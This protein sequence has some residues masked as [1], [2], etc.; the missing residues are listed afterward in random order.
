ME[1]PDQNKVIG[2]EIAVSK[3]FY[4]DEKSGYALKEVLTIDPIV[5]DLNAV[6]NEA[7][8]DCLKQL[9][10]MGTY[11][12]VAQKQGYHGEGH[13]MTGLV[14]TSSLDPRVCMSVEF[15][16]RWN[17]DSDSQAEKTGEK[18]VTLKW[19]LNDEP[20]DQFGVKGVMPEHPASEEELD[21][22][23]KL[24]EMTSGQKTESRQ[25]V[26]AA[27]KKGFRMLGEADEEGRKPI[28]R[29]VTI[30]LSLKEA[31]QALGHKDWLRVSDYLDADEHEDV[32]HPGYSVNDVQNILAPKGMDNVEKIFPTEVAGAL[33]DAE[34]EAYAGAIKKER[35][36]AIEQ[37]FEKIQPT[38]EYQSGD[39]EW[40]SVRGCGIVSCTLN[41][42]KD[43]V[44]LKIKNPEHLIND[45]VNGVGLFA[46]ELDPYQAASDAEIKSGII[47]TADDYFDVYGDKPKEAELRY[48]PE[49][50]DDF[51]AERL[52]YY[53]SEMSSDQIADA[54]IDAVDSGR[55]EDEQE[56]IDLASKL[57][58]KS[59]AEI[60]KAVK[61][62]HLTSAEK[63]QKR[64]GSVREESVKRSGRKINESKHLKGAAMRKIEEGVFN[65]W[66]AVDFFGLP[67]MES[68]EFKPASA[69][70]VASVEKKDK[71]LDKKVSELG[72]DGEP[73]KAGE[74][75]AK[76]A[77]EVKLGVKSGESEHKESDIKVGDAEDG[78]GE[79]VKG[80]GKSDS[81]Q[82]ALP[83]AQVKTGDAEEGRGK[84]M[85]D[86]RRMAGKSMSEEM[87]ARLVEW[88][89]KKMAERMGQKKIGK[90]VPARK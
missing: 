43:E 23:S 32:Y 51:F 37:A 53:I 41:A 54:V 29:E 89:K 60:A 26:L 52:E 71:E 82:K 56:A 86:S 90:K 69:P 6:S 48:V 40:I 59:K 28:E 63:Y 85:S 44:I 70:H 10:A 30:K 45:I 25:P 58:K 19:F 9:Q 80:Q 46:P 88:R 5:M 66:E 76:P 17:K 57:S 47:A 31:A 8:Q 61:A 73:N 38:G 4:V 77:S 13:K 20:K 72:G 75:I 36:H 74:A 22:I 64:A 87:K 49:I 15:G 39:G 68:E 55:I 7:L 18:D 21:I 14:I 84:V 50:N 34:R 24:R 16:R 35:Y 12:E 65:D 83:A 33:E 79:H 67:K 1:A 2:K 27:I 42:P 11:D 3:A 81:Q 62:S 78:H